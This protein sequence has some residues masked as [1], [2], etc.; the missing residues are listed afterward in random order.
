MRFQTKN[1]VLIAQANGETLRIEPW[2]K[3]SLRVRATMLPE[4]SGKDWALTEVPEKTEAK[5]E[6]FEVD[7]LEIDGSMGKRTSASITNGKIRAVVNFAGV[8]LLTKIKKETNLEMQIKNILRYKMLINW[9]Y[10]IGYLLVTPFICIFL[11]T[12]RHLWWLMITMFGLILA[13]VLT[14]YFLFHHVSDRIKELTH[15]NKELMELKKKHKE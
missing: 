10:I 6:Q 4:F 1:G 14:D 9:S 12:Y 11:Y 7:H 8:I 13:G 15:V 2:G 3:D 5:A